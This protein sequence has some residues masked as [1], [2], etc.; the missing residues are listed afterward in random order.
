M[1]YSSG[2]DRINDQLLP[3]HVDRWVPPKTAHLNYHDISMLLPFLRWLPLTGAVDPKAFIAER[4]K[5][6]RAFVSKND[7]LLS[8]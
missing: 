4:N 5:V 7:Q 1:M 3:S 2:N 6:V 8:D